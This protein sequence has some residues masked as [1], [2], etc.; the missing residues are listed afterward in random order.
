MGVYLSPRAG[1]WDRGRH[2]LVGDV[3]FR[4]PQRASAWWSS[5]VHYLFLDDPR[6][7]TVVGEP[8]YTNAN[9]LA[10]DM[11][12]GFHVQKL[13]DL[14]HKRSAIVRC[15]RIRFFQV[16]GFGLPAS[17]VKSK[18]SRSKDTAAVGQLATSTQNM[19][20]SAKL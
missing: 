20:L 2:S 16:I 4:G 11:A 12:N 7:V 15:E 18:N 19:R 9:V 10:Y 13:A 17:A 5:L 8:K 1:D 3:R 6:T 14:P